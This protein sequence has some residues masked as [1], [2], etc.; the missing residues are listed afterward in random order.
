MADPEAAA[1]DEENAFNPEAS[2]K[3]DIDIEFV[4]EWAAPICSMLS[5]WSVCS[6]C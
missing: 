5:A 6:C 4:R 1:A 2:V 3:F